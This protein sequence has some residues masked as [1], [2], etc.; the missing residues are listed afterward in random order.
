MMERALATGKEEECLK[1][2]NDFVLNHQELF[3]DDGL[4]NGNMNPSTFLTEYQKKVYKY[5]SSGDEQGIQDAQFA[6]ALGKLIIPIRNKYGFRDEMFEFLIRSYEQS[7]KAENH[8]QSDN[9]N[10][11]PNGGNNFSDGPD[12]QI[13]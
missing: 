8:N 7:G 12:D 13:P 4:L 11:P 3:K 5:L 6:F 10:N 9:K 1:L 2:I